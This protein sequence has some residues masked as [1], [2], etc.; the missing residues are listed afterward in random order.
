[1]GM[2][3]KGLQGGPPGHLPFLVEGLEKLDVKVLQT[4]YGSRTNVKT[5]RSRVFDVFESI[6]SLKKILSQNNI[7]IIHL[8][9]AFD[10]Y[11]LLRDFTTLFFLRSFKAK[12][13]LKFHGSEASFLQTKNR[14]YKY[15][16]KKVA[17]W[18]DGFGLL[19]SEEKNNFTMAG[20]PPEKLFLVKNIVR[21]S[22][23]SKNTKFRNKYS[24]VEIP[25]L[26][27]VARL[28][29]SKGLM[30]TLQAVIKL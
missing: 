9:S 21:P 19:S 30:D 25:I 18:A 5:L 20:F 11:S 7:D 24:N 10:F 14:V 4:L 17:Q 8:N 6:V 1:M 22:V 2:P 29:P 26:L 16:I 23:Y 27:F 12:K 28:I 3:N 15:M 13:F